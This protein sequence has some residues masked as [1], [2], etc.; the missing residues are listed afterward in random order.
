[1][2][3]SRNHSANYLGD[4]AGRKQKHIKVNYWQEGVT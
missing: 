1:M 3:T 4:D 2:V